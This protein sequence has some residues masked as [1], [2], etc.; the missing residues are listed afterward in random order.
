MSS[1]RPGSRTRPSRITRWGRWILHAWL[2]AIVLAAAAPTCELLVAHSHDGP[3]SSVVAGKPPQIAGGYATHADHL[4][5]L[6]QAD[7]ALQ[8]EAFGTSD[9][10]SRLLDA[11]LA[12]SAAIAWIVPW[13]AAS[14]GRLSLAALRDPGGAANRLHLVLG[15]LLN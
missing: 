14:V 1:P 9:E 15:R 10:R 12:P 13:S 8:P 11:A 6:V 4:P 5:C 7:L 3:A 2:A